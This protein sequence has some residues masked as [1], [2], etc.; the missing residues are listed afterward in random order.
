MTLYFVIPGPPRTLKNH[1]WRT[2]SGKQMPSKAYQAWN[3]T[4]QL[5]LLDWK[6]KMR[7]YGEH[8]PLLPITVP[9][10]CRALF[11][12]DRLAGDAVGYF[13]G[14][15]DTLEEARIVENDVLV[16]SWDGSRLFKDAANPRIEVT[17]GN[18]TCFT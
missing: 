14:L 15:A 8:A 7:Q 5:H 18:S 6:L 4:A 3:Q 2:K 1:G 13:Q 12:R 17:L 9:V 11:Y 16:V 10:N